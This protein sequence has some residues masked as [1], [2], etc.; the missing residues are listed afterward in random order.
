MN[1][2]ANDGQFQFVIE[3]DR[4]KTNAII[5]KLEKGKFTFD[6]SKVHP[7]L[8]EIACGGNATKILQSCRLGHFR[9][10]G[11]KEAPMPY[12]IVD[13]SEKKFWPGWNKEERRGLSMTKTNIFLK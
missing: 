1:E 6:E 10:N 4:G 3:I 5:A 2:F 13:T 9:R 12:I 7:D 11:E 8:G